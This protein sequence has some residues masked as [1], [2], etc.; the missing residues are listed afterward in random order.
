MKRAYALEAIKMTN[1]M[2]ATGRIRVHYTISGLTHTVSVFCRNVQNQSGSYFINSRTLDENDVPWIYAAD[3]LVNSLQAIMPAGVTYSVAELQEYDGLI[4][5]TTD[6]H[7]L[8]PAEAFGT[9]VPA[10]QLTLTFR[11]KT[12]YHVK[13]VVMETQ[14]A[15]G[16]KV[17]SPTGGDSDLDALVAAWTSTVGNANDPFAWAVGRSNQYLAASPFISATVSLNRKLRRARG[18]A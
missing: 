7:A 9:S 1:P 5:T 16:A 17:I 11:D 4:W 6:T 10:G 13:L 15:P 18:M 2:A 8:T 3:R 12:N 14:E